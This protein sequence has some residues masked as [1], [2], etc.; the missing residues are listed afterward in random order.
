MKTR[1]GLSNLIWILPVILITLVIVLSLTGYSQKTDYNFKKPKTTLILPKS[2]HEISGISVINNSTIAC[3]E[4]ENGILFMYDILANSVVKQ[5]SFS[6]DGDY[7][8]ISRV[9]DD[10]YI[11]RS[12]GALFEIENYASTDF[13]LVTYSPNVPAFDNEGLCYDA[14]NNR[15]LIAC[16]S[17]PE[18][19][20]NTKDLRVIYGFNLETKKLSNK[21]IFKFKLDDVKDYIKSENKRHKSNKDK[22][23]ASSVKLR[24]SDICINPVNHKFYMLSAVDHLLLVFESNG[25]IDRVVPLNHKLLRQPEGIAFMDNGDM[26]ISSEADNKKP[27][28]LLFKYKGK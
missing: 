3:I 11:L 17:N 16:K 10:M 19:G 12:D 15:L 26:L 25:K 28:L 5:Y 7:E 18:K 1:K 8:A 14:P 9:G 21:P 20:H 6:T 13:K 23:D 27:T 2:L 22:I 24:I 4:D